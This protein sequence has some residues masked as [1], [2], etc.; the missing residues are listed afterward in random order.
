MQRS[1]LVLLGDTHYAL[2]F[3]IGFFAVLAAAL[4]APLAGAPLAPTLRI[5]SPD[6]ALMRFFFAAMFA[7]SPGGLAISASFSC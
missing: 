3:F 7:Y 4:N 6:P 2:L 5:V 1:N